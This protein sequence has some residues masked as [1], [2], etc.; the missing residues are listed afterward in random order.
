[1]K[2]AVETEKYC[3]SIKLDKIKFSP[4][5]KENIE[6]IKK[7]KS[8]IRRMIPIIYKISI[9]GRC[10]FDTTISHLPHNKH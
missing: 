3:G 7:G 5:Q 8:I 2:V 1:M 6:R 9:S 10:N 4:P